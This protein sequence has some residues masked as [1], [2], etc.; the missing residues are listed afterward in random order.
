MA[1]EYRIHPLPILRIY[2]DKGFFTYLNAYGEKFWFPVYS[3]YIEGAEKNLLVDTGCTAADMRKYS[4]FTSQAEDIVPF[5]DNLSKFGLSPQDIDIVI[6]THLH[7]DHFL[8]TRKCKNATVIVQED[9]L[10][11]AY[12]PHPLFARSYVKEWYEGV[13]FEP[14]K[15]NSEILPGIN[16][17]NL[18]GHTAGSQ[19]VAIAT[20]AGTA[21]IAGFCSVDETF[22]DKDDV[23]SPILVPGI[24]VDSL[25][26]YDSIV[27]IRQIADL[28]VPTH[29]DR[30]LNGE[31][32][33]S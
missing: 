19:G 7:L 27:K 5:E 9:E 24:L 31:P 14:V 2:M 25:K 33:P 4:K 6:Q 10:Q 13:K 16:V 29:S 22:G 1:N 20:K 23:S 15:G 3:F 21:V 32:I 18:P 30:F 11:F 28:I 26:A 8:N 17:I 12:N